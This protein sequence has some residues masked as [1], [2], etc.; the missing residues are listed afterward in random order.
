MLRESACPRC[1]DCRRDIVDYDGRGCR[2]V[3]YL[4]VPDGYDFGSLMKHLDRAEVSPKWRAVYRY[5]AA[6][7]QMSGGSFMDANSVIL[8]ESDSFPMNIATLHYSYY[9][10]QDDVLQWL[11]TN[12]SRIQCV[13]G[14]GLNFPRV[15]DFGDAQHP[16]LMD[17]PDGIDTMLFLM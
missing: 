6:L 9:S 16:G 17:Y 5:V 10:N 1:Q 2:S 14:R 15:V 12:D 11:Q 3:S 7:M 4:L 13:V 8:L